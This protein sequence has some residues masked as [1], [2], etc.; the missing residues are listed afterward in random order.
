MGPGL[1]LLGQG[2]FFSLLP[3][4]QGVSTAEV[5]FPQAETKSETWGLPSQPALQVP[6]G[7]ES[8]VAQPS[9]GGTR[10]CGMGDSLGCGR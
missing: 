1:A 10:I 4:S 8:G 2:H 7:A 9:L 5:S 3:P 6:H